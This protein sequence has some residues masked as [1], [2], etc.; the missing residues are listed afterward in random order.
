MSFNIAPDSVLNIGH[1]IVD[2][3]FVEL[4]KVARTAA[5]LRGG[6]FVVGRRG[7]RCCNS[8]VTSLGISPKILVTSGA[9]Q[10]WVYIF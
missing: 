5:V 10:C 4:W 2:V 8:E 1:F 9:D 3:K 6:V 7:V